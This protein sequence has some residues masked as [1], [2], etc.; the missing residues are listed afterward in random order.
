[1]VND[2]IEFSIEFTE[3]FK[4][5]N[6]F[7]G[8]LEFCNFA[9]IED[10][11]LFNSL[12]SYPN[13]SLEDMLTKFVSKYQPYKRDKNNRMKQLKPSD[14]KSIEEYVKN[15]FEYLKSTLKINTWKI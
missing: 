5:R 4:D 14:C 2:A 3:I 13:V 1:M 9:Q 15:K 8:K 10:E 6:E 7:D 11:D 12:L